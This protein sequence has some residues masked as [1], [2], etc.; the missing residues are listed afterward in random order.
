MSGCVTDWFSHLISK[1]DQEKELKEEQQ[2]K[3]VEMNTPKEV[4]NKLKEEK[5]ITSLQLEAEEAHVNGK[6]QEYQS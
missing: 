4:T 3:E 1:A 2:K 6:Q 5:P